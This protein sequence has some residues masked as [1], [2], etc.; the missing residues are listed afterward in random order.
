MNY[1]SLLKQLKKR[2]RS[3]KRWL[4]LGSLLLVAGLAAV[5]VK[6]VPSLSGN[7]QA[8]PVQ[9]AANKLGV[10]PI[11]EMSREQEEALKAIANGEQERTVSVQKS[12]ICGEETQQVG[13]MGKEN[14]LKLSDEHPQWVIK[15][16]TGGDVTFVE[17]IEDLS[18]KC[19]E[20]AYFGIDKNGN[21]SLFEGIPGRDQVIRTFFQLNVQH[22]KSSLPPDAINQLYEGIRISD[23][24]EYYSVLSTFSDFAVEAVRERGEKPKA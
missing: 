21:L 23:L 24:T 14:I 19:K 12:Y 11:A 9:A 5:S 4:T 3:K 22:L 2:L 20:T 10:R 8:V 13:L 18:Q 15:L 6:H 17:Q 7:R 16:S 1:S